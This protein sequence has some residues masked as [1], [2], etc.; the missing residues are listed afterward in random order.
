MRFVLVIVIL[1]LFTGC[2]STIGGSNGPGSWDDPDVE[3]F[4]K[5]KERRLTPKNEGEH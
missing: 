2:E 3:Y 5:G 1:L 4:P